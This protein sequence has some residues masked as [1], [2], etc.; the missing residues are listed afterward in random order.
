M[1]LNEKEI[2]SLIFGAVEFNKENG[3]IRPCR[4]TKEIID[5]FEGTNKERRH[6]RSFA[7][8]GITM[9]FTTNSEFFSFQYECFQA[10]GSHHYYFDVYIDGLYTHHIGNTDVTTDK[11]TFRIDL[12][13]GNKKVLIYF[14]NFFGMR[15]KNVEISDNAKIKPVKKDRKFLFYG[16]SITQGHTTDFPSFTF[17]NIVSRAFNAQCVNKGIGGDYYYP[18]I[19]DEKFNY[20]PDAII[21]AF[22]TNDW[23]GGKDIG[24]NATE[25]YDRLTKIYPGVKIFTLLPLWR[26]KPPKQN[27]IT[28]DEMR[29]I[30]IKVCKNY[31][32]ITVIDAIDFIPHDGNF[33]IPDLLHPNTLGFRMY[34]ENVVNALK[35]FMV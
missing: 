31:K 2:E 18:P 15:I 7:M 5:F 23:S 3:Y 26:G 1:K 32:D 19:L 24:K 25:F 6:L 9:E 33:F 28:F 20:K 10:S 34:G 17:S 16:D 8:C 35:P 27:V 21:V 29:E 11:K 13:K 14:S 4:F 12:K 22:G 30:L